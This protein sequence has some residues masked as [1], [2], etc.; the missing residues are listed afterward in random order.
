MTEI[1]EKML[2][3]PPKKY[4]PVP[5]WSWN[6][7]LDKTE[8]ARQIDLMDKAGL[9]GYFMHARGGLLTEY[10]GDE[11]FENVE[12]GVSEAQKRE[13]MRG[14]TTKT[15]GRAD[16][17]GESSSKIPNFSRPISYTK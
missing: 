3:N 11:W 9:G 8:T 17:W 2:E 15:A 7:K 12:I 13:C 1:T 14:H 4:R 6:E 5:F 16:S 10:M